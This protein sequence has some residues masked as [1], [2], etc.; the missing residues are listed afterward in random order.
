MSDSSHATV[1]VS[2]ERDYNVHIGHGVIDLLA[3]DPL[4]RNRRGIIVTGTS[5]QEISRD[6]RE[7]IGLDICDV[8]VVPDGEMAKTVHVAT[9]CWASFA[10]AGIGRADVVISVGGGTVTDVAGFVAATWMRG[11]DIVHVPTTTAAMVDAAIG[12][13]TGINTAHGKNLV[14]SF[15]SPIA[16]YCDVD[17]IASLPT[18]DHAAG[19]AEA[20]KCGFIVDG[21]LLSLFR[22]HGADLRDVHHPLLPEVIRRAVQVKADVVSADFTESAPGIG[23]ELLNYGHTFGHALELL[24]DYTL[25]HGDAVAMGMV[26][27]AELSHGLGL[28]SAEFRDEHYQLIA[29]LGLPVRHPVTSPQEAVIAMGRDKKARGGVIRFILLRGQGDAVAVEDASADDVASA[30]SRC[31]NS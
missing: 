16:V 2:A 9:D 30:L 21:E 8:V 10:Q 14:G 1:Q 15:H 19:L 11:V 23:R 7:R 20:L 18:A 5:V 13:K 4:V 22:D 12:G 3:A 25:R 24:S 28:A 31:L 26:F 6:V 27:A 29:Q 17:V